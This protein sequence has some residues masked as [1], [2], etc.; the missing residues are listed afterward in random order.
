MKALFVTPS[1]L[2]R[3][4]FDRVADIRAWVWLGDASWDAVNTASEQ[5][6][7]VFSNNRLSGGDVSAAHIVGAPSDPW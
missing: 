4:G 6:L 2:H 7:C 5:G 3:A 1:V